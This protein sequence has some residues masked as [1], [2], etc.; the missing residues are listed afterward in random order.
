MGKIVAGVTIQ[1]KYG[2]FLSAACPLARESFAAAFVWRGKC[3]TLTAVETS[4][5]FTC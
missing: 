2:G 5:D 4:K 1:G 3:I